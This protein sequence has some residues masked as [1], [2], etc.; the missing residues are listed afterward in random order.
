MIKSITICEIDKVE[1]KINSSII[2]QLTTTKAQIKQNSNNINEK[3]ISFRKF[4]NSYWEKKF[5]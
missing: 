5:N 4:Y 2:I 3:T 1:K